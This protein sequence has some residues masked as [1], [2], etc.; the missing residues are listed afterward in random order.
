MTSRLTPIVHLSLDR[1]SSSSRSIRYTQLQCNCCLYIVRLFRLGPK[2][3]QQTAK[4]QFVPNGFS[5][6][7]KLCRRL[8]IFSN[9]RKDEKNQAV[10]WVCSKNTSVSRVKAPEAN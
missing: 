4:G 2:Y 10:T 9:R 1:R 6:H 7:V 3:G 8:G 5:V